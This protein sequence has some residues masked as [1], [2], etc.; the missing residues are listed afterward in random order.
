MKIRVQ[1]GPDT[2]IDGLGST[3]R[4]RVVYGAAGQQVNSL[5]S[6]PGPTCRVKVLCSRY[7]LAD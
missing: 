3:R 1:Y 5:S 4:I 2:W 7:S 6:C